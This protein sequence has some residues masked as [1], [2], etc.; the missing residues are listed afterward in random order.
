MFIFVALLKC[1]TYLSACPSHVWVVLQAAWGL[2][3]D[4]K[5]GFAKKEKRKQVRF[6]FAEYIEIKRK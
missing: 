1:P 4:G 2:G 3:K 6:I 5:K